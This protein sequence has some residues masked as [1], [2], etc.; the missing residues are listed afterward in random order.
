MVICIGKGAA[1]KKKSCQT[2][3]LFLLIILRNLSLIPFGLQAKIPF[4]L[5]IQTLFSCTRGAYYC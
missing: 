5:Y 1:L 2:M 3:T 4:I